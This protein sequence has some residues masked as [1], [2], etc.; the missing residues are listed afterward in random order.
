MHTHAVPLVNE[1]NWHCT[2]LVGMLDLTVKENI[3]VCHASVNPPLTSPDAAVPLEINAMSIGVDQGMNPA[4]VMELP[5][6]VTP[7]G[8]AVVVYTV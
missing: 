2:Q 7:P 8:R 5:Q 6:A 1:F 3:L 4:D